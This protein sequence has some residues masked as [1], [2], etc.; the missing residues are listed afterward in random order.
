MF[1]TSGDNRLTGDLNAAAANGAVESYRRAA[2]LFNL[3]LG[4]ATSQTEAV[5]R[6]SAQKLEVA[7]E[8][9]TILTNGFRDVA[10]EWFTVLQEGMTK[11]LDAMTRVAGCR[12]FQD[13]AAAQSEIARDGLVRSREATRRIREMSMRVAEE[14]IRISEVS[15]RGD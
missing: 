9:S 14:V 2:N 12:S 8:M 13:V 10:N 3:A 15:K 5:S 6:Q 1:E 7:L 4:F 11:N